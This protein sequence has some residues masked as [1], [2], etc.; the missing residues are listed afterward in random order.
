MRK[1][2]QEIK[3][4]KPYWLYDGLSLLSAI[5]TIITAIIAIIKATIDTYKLEDGTYIVSYNKMLVCISIV[6]CFLLI[7]CVCKVMKYGRILRALRAEFSENYYGF[8]H[9]FRNSYFD[10]LMEYKLGNY[11]NI[12]DGIRKL[13][14]DTKEFLQTAL[15]Y[16][17]QILQKS[18]GEKVCACIKLIE[19]SGIA[20]GIDKEKATVTT[21]CRSKNT[22]KNRKAN[23]GVDT[24]SI[25][26]KDNTDFYDILDEESKD[27]NSYFYQ[28]NLL[29]YDKDLK[30]AGKKYKNTTE[31]FQKYYK[32][33]IVVPIRVNKSHLFYV[34]NN[35]GYDIVGFLCVDSLSINAF[36]KNDYDKNNNTNIVKSFAAEIYIILNKYNFYLKKISGGSHL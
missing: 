27:T 29:Q 30:K 33:A 23:D 13:T 9:D 3:D 8:L 15:D 2:L 31:D 17:C 24:G 36:R 1:K 26:I 20:T 25:R 11:N 21:F 35:N 6:I 18:T 22:D 7:V 12:S 34:N 4:E 16:L 28:G 5:V 19:N 14:D 32:G 10:V